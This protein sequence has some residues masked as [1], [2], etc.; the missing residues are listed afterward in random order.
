MK[1]ATLLGG[2]F[3]VLEG[4]RVNTLIYISDGFGFFKEEGEG[5]ST[6]NLSCLGETGSYIKDH[7]CVFCAREMGNNYIPGLYH[8]LLVQSNI[9]RIC[10]LQR[11]S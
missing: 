10:V 11:L 2:N 9:L 5:G 7:N 8:F 1:V 3:E 6:P 4:F